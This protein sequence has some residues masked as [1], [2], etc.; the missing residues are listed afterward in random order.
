[1]SPW[2]VVGCSDC[3]TPW[4]IERQQ[5]REQARVSCPNCGKSIDADRLRPLAQHDTKAGAAELRSRIL[6]SRAGKDE[7]YAAMDD[8]AEQADAVDDQL[9]RGP[10]IDQMDLRPTG[11][12]RY[13]ELVDALDERRGSRFEEAAEEA[14]GLYDDA[15]ADAVDAGLPEWRRNFFQDDV[16]ELLEKFGADDVVDERTGGLVLDDQYPANATAEIV[17]DENATVARSSADNPGV[18]ADLVEQSGFQTALVE[19]VRRF[20]A[21][22]T[23]SELQ[24]ALESRDVAYSLRSVVERLA[25]GV[26]RDA[27]DAAE[28]LLR[29]LVYGGEDL[30]G[31]LFLARRL[32]TQR[33]PVEQILGTARLVGWATGEHE[34]NTPTIS[35]RLKE[36]FQDQSLD[37]RERVVQLLWQLARNC[38]VVVIGSPIDLRRLAVS[39]DLKRTAF[40]ERWTGRGRTAP[41]DE[42]VDAALDV[43]DRESTGAQILRVLHNEHDETLSYHALAAALGVSKPTISNWVQRRDDALVELGLVETIEAR[44]RSHVE[45]GPA[46]REAI[47][48]IDTETPRQQRLDEAFSDS[49]HPSDHGRVNPREHEDPPA[50]DPRRKG[51]GLAPVATLS[52]EEGYGAAASVRENGFSVVDHPVE[53]AEDYRVPGLWIDPGGDRVVGSTEYVNP[54][55]YWVSTAR[56]LTDWRI[57]EYCLTPKRLESVDYDFVDLFDEHRQVLR[58]SRCLGHLPDDY[59]TVEEFVEALQ[60]ARE[61]LEELTTNLHNGD[62]EDEDSFRGT[63]LRDALGLAGTIVHIMDLVDVD[64][65]REVRLPTFSSDFDADRWDD[66]VRTLTIGAAIQSRYAQFSAYRQLFEQRE[67]KLDWTIF[68]D[69]DAADPIGELIG[70]FVLAGNFGAVDGEK[71]AAFVDDLEAELQAPS[72]VRD[73]A[74]EFTVDIPVRAFE[75]DREQFAVATSRMASEKNLRPTR[76]TVSLL[77]LFT[78]NPY[79][80]ATALN[81]LE[82]E[83]VHRELRPSEVRYAL[84]KLPVDRLLPHC[85]PGSRAIVKALLAVDEPLSTGD[86]A[87]AAGVAR[88]TISRNGEAA[89]DR[90]QALGLLERTDEG[91]RLPIAFRIDEE[92]HEEIVPWPV[93]GADRLFV[94]D[95]FY[96]AAMELVD[97]PARWGDP[98][99]PVCGCWTALTDEGLPDLRPLLEHWEWLDPWVGVLED[100]LEARSML[101]TVDESYATTESVVSFGANPNQA[102]IQAT[103]STATVLSDD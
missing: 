54:M 94:R 83:D 25:R 88:S 13:S 33:A 62:F 91:W 40:N 82:T 21:G 3:G 52:R 56:A 69:V 10:D 31:L 38:E 84:S 99:D 41:I 39:H 35:V 97:D 24:E 17:L 8:Y 59:E 22:R 19:G 68:A 81:W 79:D 74:P 98:G 67:Q 64:V 53:K 86:L 96:E 58:S 93:E 50:G 103:A 72:E 20:A 60:E 55:Q 47:E 65:V 51:T 11:T 101:V 7:R 76:E 57:F 89:G 5:R 15:F 23:S 2:D 95:V 43:L 45:L 49:L 37:Q 75:F 30:D 80:V 87:D 63:I 32:G 36:S 14:L 9:D 92:R 70:S 1:M 44:G 29:R 16:N 26:E 42:R 18:W 4:L 85:S 34:V 102:S 71:R 46:G 12:D 66:L 73:D 77:R 100:V 78:G 48:T 27:P 6:A 61:N 90:L 28:D